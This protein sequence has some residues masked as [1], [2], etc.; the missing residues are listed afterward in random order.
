M[1]ITNLNDPFVRVYELKGLKPLHRNFLC[2]VWSFQVNNQDCYLSN[3][4]WAEFLGCSP[5][6]VGRIK[7]DLKSLNFIETDD[8]FVRLKY[9]MSTIIAILS[10][11][12]VPK[13]PKKV[14]VPYWSTE[15]VVF[16][17][18]N[19]VKTENNATQFDDSPAQFE[20]SQI[21]TSESLN[22]NNTILNQTD[23]QLNKDNEIIREIKERNKLGNLEWSLEHFNFIETTSIEELDLLWN[24]SV[25]RNYVLS[26]WYNYISSIELKSSSVNL[27]NNGNYFNILRRILIK[28]E[29]NHFNSDFL[30]EIDIN[31]FLMFIKLM[32]QSFFD[33]IED[34]SQP[35]DREVAD[36]V[37]MHII[38]HG[39][40]FK[41]FLTPEKI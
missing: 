5:A 36:D 4:A 28:A 7:K 29:N 12:Y 38:D 6:T 40:N 39:N 21:Q 17:D 24:Q 2:K 14:K 35:L 13:Y 31:D 30:K 11:N 20:T 27:F 18:E 41:Y 33:E 34:G 19:S 32:Y 3:R 25:Q 37:E 26:Y 16:E 1:N 23:E 9:N 10:E 15:N 22:Q 8:V